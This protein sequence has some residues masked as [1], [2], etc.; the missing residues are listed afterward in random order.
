MD[1][2]PREFIPVIARHG[3]DTVF[4]AGLDA[5]GFP[6]TWA[7]DRHE[8]YAIKRHIEKKGTQ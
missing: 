1:P 3:E 2:W 7:T 4:S 5:L 6:G 8:F